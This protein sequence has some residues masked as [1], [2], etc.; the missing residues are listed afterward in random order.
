MGGGTT[1]NIRP[2]AMSRSELVTGQYFYDLGSHLTAGTCPKQPRPPTTPINLMGLPELKNFFWVKN[3]LLVFLNNIMKNY[4]NYLRQILE[5]AQENLQSKLEDQLED[6]INNHDT[7][8]TNL[9]A[10]GSVE[11]TRANVSGSGY[12]GNIAHASNILHAAHM[13]NKAAGSIL[14]SGG[15][16]VDEAQRLHNTSK[17]LLSDHLSEYT[18]HIQQQQD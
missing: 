9:G 15:D 13:L 10:H 3:A 2:R 7:N 14:R 12:S 16:N 5:N 4:K 6:S 1:I 18:D 11:K 17:S 8:L